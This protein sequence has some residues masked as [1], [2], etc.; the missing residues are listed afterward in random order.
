MNSQSLS[1]ITTYLLFLAIG[2]SALAILLLL[3]FIGIQILQKI[4]RRHAARS[5]LDQIGHEAMVIKTIRPNKLGQIRYTSRDGIRQADAEA[6]QIIRN[7]N[8][9]MIQGVVKDRFKVRRLTE[10]EQQMKAGQGEGSAK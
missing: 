9:V 3:V 8:V 2:I 7:G 5:D 4:A 10:K 1:D 6:D